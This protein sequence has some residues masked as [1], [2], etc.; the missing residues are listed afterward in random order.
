MVNSI[1]VQLMLF[2]KENYLLLSLIQFC[3]KTLA[4]AFLSLA[5]VAHKVFFKHRT[6]RQK[7]T[8]SQTH[9]HTLSYVA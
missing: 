3:I 2:N 4:A 9:T 6:N 7:Y 1:T 5:M 8:V